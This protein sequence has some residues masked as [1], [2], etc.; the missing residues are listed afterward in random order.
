MPTPSQDP[1][2]SFLRRI[3]M[4]FGAFFSLL[5]NADKAARYDR[6]DEPRAEP[7]APPPVAAPKPLP[8]P[9]PP[10][11]VPP[12]VLRET[13][14]D[15]A[16]QL[17]A[18]LQREGRFIDFMQDDIKGYADAD[19]GAAVRVVHEGCR[20]VLQEHFRIEPVRPEN[21][22]SRVTLQPGFDAASVKL[23]GNV[24][25]QPPFTGTLSHRGWR[26]AEVKLPKL[27]E[28]HDARVLAQAEVE[29]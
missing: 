3:P 12:P 9:K 2:P 22:G 27:A 14:P 5:G 21:E 18:L 28:K 25:G 24:V 8:M 10:A 4:A 17:L 23:T 16:L 1:K 26:A 11:P 20:K 13:G 6:L 19:I 29:L 15:A 7:P